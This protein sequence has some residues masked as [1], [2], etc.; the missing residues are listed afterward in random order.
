MTR[1]I[2]RRNFLRTGVAVAA[3]TVLAGCEQTRRWVILE[4]YV[5]APEQQLD[6]IPT[7]YASACGGCSA[8]C[9]T[10]V[11]VLNGRATKIEGNPEHP[12]NQG[13]LC[14]QGQAGLQLL[15]NPDRLSEP[16]Q[17][18]R[19]GSREFARVPWESA[20]GTLADRI[21][22]AG[23]AVAV[24]GG[25]GIS[26]HVYDLFLRLTKAIGAPTPVIFDL[27][28]TWNGQAVLSNVDN[29]L[30]GRAAL[31][32]YNVAGA[33]V[34]FSFGADFVATWLSA[35]RYGMEYGVFR[36]QPLGQRGYLVQFEPRMSS[37][38]AKAD[39]WVAIRPGTEG[40]VAQAI[41]RIIA[42][43]KLGPADWAARAAGVA[44][45]ADVNAIA[46][47]ADVTV[48]QL[49][50]LARIFATA[51]HPIAIPGNTLQGPNDALAVQAL[52]TIAA[53]GV[54]LSADPPKPDILS[55]QPSTYADLQGLIDRMR[56]GA[57]KVLLVYGTNPVYEL[58][59]KAGFLD[60]LGNVDFVVNFNT[61]LDE[62]AANS[63][64]VLS[65]LTY[66]EDWGYHFVAPNF[67]T[68]IITS[69]QPV[70]TPLNNARSVGDVLIAVGKNIP[71]AAG[72]FPWPD[73]VTFLRETIGALP[74]GAAGGSGIDVL[75]ARFLQH[76]GWWPAQAPA[77]TPVSANLPAT[78][79]VAAAQVPGDT[80]QYPYYLQVYVPVIMG[81]GVGANLPWL[82]GSPEPLTS[83]SWQTWV[84]INPATAKKLGVQKGDVVRIS[85]P[86]GDLEAPVYVYPP[87]REDTIAIPMGQGHTDLGRYARNR[88][89]NPMNLLGAQAGPGGVAP[90][91][92]VTRCQVTPTGT[93]T[94]VA[95]FEWTPGVEQGFINKGFPGE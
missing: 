83:I 20:L 47:A 8:G 11:R 25:P 35:T 76:G 19:R 36:S 61:L 53:G 41:A 38:G 82:Q 66:L 9:G 32:G 95:T 54:S 14:A 67:G 31:P 88:G 51:Q 5:R 2:S 84:E 79:N 94:R 17:T 28:S 1:K 30:Y 60:A 55:P 57:V 90:A 46:Q 78:L 77:P 81:T 22:S 89:A 86:D 50:Q 87:V 65:S 70:V 59:E 27:R 26:G 6:G 18:T 92:S 15:Y 69:E 16:L 62:T 80:A 73:Q 23:N 42:D 4:P 33:D 75:W 71:S 24:L 10:I 85:T 45:K 7:W 12:L 74:P 43:Q 91:W 63:N 29:Q 34:V 52:N 3:S 13:K 68:P 58:P 72:S 21:K 37:S 48:A 56:S 64:L 49:T 40:L 39:Q 93:S 44:G